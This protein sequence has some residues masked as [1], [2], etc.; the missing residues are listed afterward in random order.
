MGAFD[1]I[2]GTCYLSLLAGQRVGVAT[3]GRWPS[4]QRRTHRP[5][6]I[7]A[8]PLQP[9]VCKDYLTQQRAG[10]AALATGSRGPNSPQ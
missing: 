1:N 5:F 4:R 7:F 2:K 9:D 8:I 6:A 10:P 3:H